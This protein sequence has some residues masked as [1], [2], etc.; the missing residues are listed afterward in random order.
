V[1]EANRELADEVAAIAAEL[2]VRPSQVALAWV[3]S[4]GDDVVPIPGTRQ[5]QRL[6]EN[7]RAVDVQ[8]DD[9]VIARL[10]TL[11]DRVAGNRAVRPENVGRE[12]PLPATAG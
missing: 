10:E 2:G 4:R 12:A 8:L 3:L 5:V 9:P 7:V 11:A 6:E 1:F